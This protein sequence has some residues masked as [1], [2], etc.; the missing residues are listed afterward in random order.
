MIILIV[1]H[2]IKIVRLA[3]ST[4]FKTNQQTPDSFKVATS[5][6]PTVMIVYSQN[7]QMAMVVF[8][9]KN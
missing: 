9:K 3:D 2:Q 6:S 1:N 5:L 8:Y 4:S 7:H